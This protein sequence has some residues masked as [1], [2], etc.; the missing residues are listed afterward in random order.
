MK[1][2]NTL[3]IA[4][5]A[6]AMLALTGCGGTEADAPAAPDAQAA[7]GAAGTTPIADPEVYPREGIE[8]E[9]AC[10]LLPVVEVE[11]AA[12]GAGWGVIEESAAECVYESGDGATTVTFTVFTIEQYDTGKNAD[13][14]VGVVAGGSGML[15]FEAAGTY[16]SLWAP[17]GRWGAVGITQV[18]PSIDSQAFIDLVE[19]GAL[20]YENTPLAN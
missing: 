15:G 19:F 14:A 5:L 16:S 20:A 3:A 7:T 18:P 11:L 6:G 1:S 10:E 17:A 9:S 12:G 4:V 2:T 8:V 13:G